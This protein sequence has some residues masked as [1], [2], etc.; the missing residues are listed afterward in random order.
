MIYRVTIS[1]TYMGVYFDFENITDAN[2]FAEMVI[3]NGKT[4]KEDYSFSATIKIIK[5]DEGDE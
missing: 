3:K 5:E 2:L 4:D 1:Q